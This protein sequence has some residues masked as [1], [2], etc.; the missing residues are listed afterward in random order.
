MKRYADRLASEGVLDAAAFEAQTKA[1]WDTLD[2]AQEQAKASIIDPIRPGFEG[3][4]KGIAPRRSTEDVA[5]GVPEKAP[6]AVPKALAAKPDGLPPHK[7]DAKHTGGGA[8][9][10]AQCV[11]KHTYQHHHS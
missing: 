2:R 4:W 7:N 6:K 11:M 3:A 1:Y 10:P 8:G 9:F 5:T